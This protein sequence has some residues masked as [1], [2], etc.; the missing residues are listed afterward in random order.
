[1]C[2]LSTVTLLDAATHDRVDGQYCGQDK[3]GNSG[4]WYCPS[5][6]FQKCQPSTVCVDHAGTRPYATCDTKVK[7]VAAENAANES[8]RILTHQT[9]LNDEEEQ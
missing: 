8:L 2:E 9:I 1:M 7:E 3:D 4:Y 5:E 6:A